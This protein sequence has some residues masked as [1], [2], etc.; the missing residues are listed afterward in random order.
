MNYEFCRDFVVRK[1]ESCA[2]AGIVCM[3]LGLAVLV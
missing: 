3:I 1:L 2:I